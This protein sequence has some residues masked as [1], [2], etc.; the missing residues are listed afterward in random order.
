M[1]KACGGRILGDG[2]A[3]LPIGSEPF[4][5][6]ERELS[7]GRRAGSQRFGLLVGSSR[8][9]TAQKSSGVAPCCMQGV[10]RTALRTEARHS[11][12]EESLLQF[13]LFRGRG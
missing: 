3:V 4:A 13:R 8:M 10:L 12:P 11:E 2:V 5:P 6:S 7:A 9:A 1:K